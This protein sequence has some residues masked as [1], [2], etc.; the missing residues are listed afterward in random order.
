MLFAAERHES[1]TETPWDHAVVSAAIARCQADS[2]DFLR[3]KL[4]RQQG[5][6]V[7]ATTMYEG[8]LGVLWAV[9]ETAELTGQTLD[10]DVPQLA[11]EI[12][13]DYTNFEAVEFT[14]LD[15]V[16]Y[17]ASYFL[18]HSGSVN[19]MQR[20]CPEQ[21]DHWQSQLLELAA[22][23][24]EN[25]TLEVLW[26]GPGSILPVL[27]NLLVEDSALTIGRDTRQ[28][29]LEL[30]QRQFDFMRQ[31]L[32]FAEDFNCQIW[33]QDLYGGQP[34]LTGAGHG[35]VGNMFPFLRGQTLLSSE[36]RE[37]LL[38]TTVETLTRTAR[39]EGGLANW[40]TN[41]DGMPADTPEFLVQWCHG[42]PGVLLSVN[43]IEK[44]YSAALDHLLLQA[45]EAIWQAGPLKKGLGLCH[46]TDGN[47][48]AFLKLFQRSGGEK[49]LERARAFA[50]HSLDQYQKLPG[51]WVGD[52]ALPLFLL[53][54]Q[55]GTSRV[56]LWDYV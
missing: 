23:N 29:L 15:V 39:H 18:G 47:G 37:W 35:F 48:F 34:R 54:C 56:P 16:N 53:A 2:I 49:W 46:G 14:D 10:L 28:K 51:F 8:A 50:M 12:F 41:L 26:G 40:P 32:Q 5:E 20:F 27:N 17:E 36:D 3:N 22:G 33:R 19:M 55:Q 13:A 52:S 4:W 9:I 11:A 43:D 6:D 38:A 25:P 31:Q 45:G 42:A 44:G 24:I 21:F 7:A 30:F 1:C